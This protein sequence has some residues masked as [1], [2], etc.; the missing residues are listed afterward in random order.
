MNIHCLLKPIFFWGGNS[1][2]LTSIYMQFELAFK[3]TA[4]VLND[5]SYFVKLLDVFFLLTFKNI[6]I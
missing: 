4:C 6:T 5:L 1:D 2:C 3:N